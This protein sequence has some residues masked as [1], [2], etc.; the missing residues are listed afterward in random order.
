MLLYNTVINQA[1]RLVL[2]STATV[3]HVGEAFDF[4][5]VIGMCGQGHV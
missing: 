1:V 3:K 5:A 4:V 2:C